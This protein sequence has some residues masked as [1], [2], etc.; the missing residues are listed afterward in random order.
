MSIESRKG[1]KAKPGNGTQLLPFIEYSNHLR[2]ME[3]VKGITDSGVNSPV[4]QA[5]QQTQKI[6]HELWAILE[7][8]RK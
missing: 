8:K 5:N 6:R 2:S 3:K 1:I 4:K 7:K